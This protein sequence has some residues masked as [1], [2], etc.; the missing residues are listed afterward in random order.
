MLLESGAAFDRQMVYWDVRPSEHLPTIEVRASDVP[1][2]VDETVLVA[3]LVRGLVATALR[4][5]ETGRTAPPVDD[6]ALRVA[7]WRSARDGLRGAALDPFTGRRTTGVQQ[8]GALI[9]HIRGALEEFGDLA[10]LRTLTGRLLA[11][12]NGAIRQRRALRQRGA[13]EDVVEQVARATLQ[14]T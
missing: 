7:Y 11:R 6:E 12:G 8:L 5:L 9:L 4:A 10:E 14:G 1:S 13:V 2:T 3:G